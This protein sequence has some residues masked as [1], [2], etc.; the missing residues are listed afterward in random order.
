MSGAK[1]EWGE[2]VSVSREVSFGREWRVS[3]GSEWN[4]R[5]GREWNGVCEWR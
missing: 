3:V 2:S 5:V 4:V 1:V